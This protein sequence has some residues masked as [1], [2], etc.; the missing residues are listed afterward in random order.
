GRRK[1]RRGAQFTNKLRRLPRP[2][3][4]C[5]G[6]FPP[7][8]AFT[9]STLKIT[10]NRSGLCHRKRI[11]RAETEAGGKTCRK[12]SPPASAIVPGLT[13]LRRLNVFLACI[14]GSVSVVTLPEENV[15]PRNTMVA[16]RDSLTC[17]FTTVRSKSL[18]RKDAEPLSP[19]NVAAWPSRS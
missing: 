8:Y 4:F 17:G 1:L 6:I 16:C 18:P 10:G 14:S 15:P 13:S 7:K 2:V 12:G 3:F 11:A 19:Q 5:I 9:L